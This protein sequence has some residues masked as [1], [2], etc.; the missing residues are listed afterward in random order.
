MPAVSF[1]EATIKIMLMLLV[2]ITVSVM[3]V[4]EDKG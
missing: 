1:V 2:G 3:R 4:L